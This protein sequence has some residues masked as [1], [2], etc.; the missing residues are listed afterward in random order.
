MARNVP[1]ALQIIFITSKNFS[2][3]NVLKT[4]FMINQK[5][6]VCVLLRNNSGLVNNVSPAI[7]LNIS[8]VKKWIASF[9]L[10]NK[11]MM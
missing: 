7:T 8:I 5:C 9:V 3:K 6:S 1:N 11:F 2:A 10:I 4:E